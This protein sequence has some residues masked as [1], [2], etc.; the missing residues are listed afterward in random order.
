MEMCWEPGENWDKSGIWT[1]M[2]DN[3][4]VVRHQIEINFTMEPNEITFVRIR[5]I[6]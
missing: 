1:E 5:K 6:G 3:I 4:N 2:I